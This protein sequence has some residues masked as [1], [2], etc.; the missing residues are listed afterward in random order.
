MRWTKHSKGLGKRCARAKCVGHS[1]DSSGSWCYVLWEGGNGEW[2]LCSPAPA[3]AAQENH[4][5]HKG[6][7]SGTCPC[8]H[9]GSKP[10]GPVSA[11][12]SR[13]PIA[14][15]VRSSSPESV[16]LTRTSVKSID[17]V[18]YHGNHEKPKLGG[19]MHTKVAS[20]TYQDSPYR[21]SS[22]RVQLPTDSE[23][24]KPHIYAAPIGLRSRMF[25]Q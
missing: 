8:L 3:V 22:M 10:R 14:G 19:Y 7:A 25:I 24:I 13:E 9:T 16:R 12:A 20:R 18:N 2:R 15:Y 17:K 5:L 21:F 23:Q 4:W 1:S 11:Q 6:V